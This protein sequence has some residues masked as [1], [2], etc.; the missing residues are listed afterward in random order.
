[1][2]GDAALHDAE[3]RMP[4]P[5]AEG[6]ARALRP[7]H[8]QAHGFFDLGLGRGQRRAFVET[9]DD[10]RA[11]QLLDFHAAF[12]RQHM[13]AA[14]NMAGKAHAL[15]GQLAQRGKAHDL[16]PAAVRQDRALPVHELVQAAQPGDAFGAG[17]QHQVIGIAQQDVGARGAHAFGHHGL[18]RSGRAHR[19]EGRGADLAARGGNHAGPGLALGCVKGEAEFRGHPAVLC[20]APVFAAKRRES[21][22]GK[23]GFAAL[24]GR[25]CRGTCASGQALGCRTLPMAAVS[26]LALRTACCAISVTEAAS[27]C[28]SLP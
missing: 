27:L 14:I 20:Q 23:A 6:I 24:R 28:V 22:G 2:G 13:L 10:I 15:F 25:S 17:A 21:Q 8:R 1:M 11:Q 9:H 7:A 5:V 18:H 12:R 19:H 26:S 3:Q 16:K 4:R